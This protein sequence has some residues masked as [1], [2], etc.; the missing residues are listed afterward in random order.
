MR[1]HPV[2]FAAACG[3]L[4]AL[5]GL[6]SGNTVYGSGY[7]EARS[8]LEG[9]GEVPASYGLWKMLATFVSF[10]SGIPGGLF[11]PSLS[12]GAGIG[13]VVA[14]WV[15][16]VDAS[17]L[18]VVGMAAYFAGVVQA[19]ITSFVIVMEMTDNH[20]MVVPLMLA[21]LLATAVSRLI[22]PRPLYKGLARNY[23]VRVRPPAPK[24]NGL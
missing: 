2:Y 11:A 18:V 21:T 12:A 1:A 7:Q 14:G 13:Q 23:L 17:S 24:E 8:L 19:P 3:L 5:I 4:L 22:C 9:S 16:P 10:I 20:D 6:A 15:T